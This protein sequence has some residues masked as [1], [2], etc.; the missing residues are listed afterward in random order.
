MDEPFVSLDD[1]TA[2]ELRQILIDMWHRV[3][4]TVLFVTHDRTEAVMLGTR[5]LRLGAGSATLVADTRIE[6]SR[7][8]RRHR[9]KV[10]AEVSRVFGPS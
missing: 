1:P 3:R 4:A 5:I 10:R 6:L 2:H 9:D 7:D 8:D